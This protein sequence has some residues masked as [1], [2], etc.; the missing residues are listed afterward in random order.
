MGSVDFS[1]AKQA[2][3][4]SGTSSVGM[5]GTQG[6]SWA[7]FRSCVF[8]TLKEQWKELLSGER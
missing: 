1:P 2:A 8:L 4:A 5:K 6:K 7:L 3:A